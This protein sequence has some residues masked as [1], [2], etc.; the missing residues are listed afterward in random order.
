MS[1]VAGEPAIIERSRPVLEAYTAKLLVLGDKPA[2]PA[3]FKL[4]VNFFAACLLE[5]M[6]EAF[7]FAEKQG[8]Q[9]GDGRLYDQR[10]ATAPCDAKVC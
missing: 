5:T 6:G 3:S 7:T 9:F 8:P 10:T 2:F 1:F 4:V